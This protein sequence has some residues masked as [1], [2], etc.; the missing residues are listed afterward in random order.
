MFFITYLLSTPS[1]SMHT[2]SSLGIKL[3][4]PPCKCTPSYHSRNSPDFNLHLQRL[5]DPVSLNGA[6]FLRV[7]LRRIHIIQE[8]DSLHLLSIEHT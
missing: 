1:S 2:I 4:N 8:H 5:Y 7:V 6:D 3:R